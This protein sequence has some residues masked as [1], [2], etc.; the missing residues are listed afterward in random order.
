MEDRQEKILDKI[1]DIN[2]ESKRSHP[3]SFPNLLLSLLA[4]AKYIL[5]FLLKVFVSS[6]DGGNQ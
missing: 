2:T 6:G 1:I 4:C 3:Q 5:I